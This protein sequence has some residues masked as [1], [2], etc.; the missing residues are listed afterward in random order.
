MRVAEQRISG[1]KITLSANRF[2]VYTSPEDKAIGFAR[3]LFQ[4]PRGRVG[5][6]SPD[7]VTEHLRAGMEFG[8]SNF[9]IIN[10]SGASGTP[11]DKYGHSYFRNAPTVSSDLVLMLRDDLDPGVP[12][13]P[14]QHVDLSFWSIPPGYPSISSNE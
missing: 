7:E 3:R 13:R 1:D 2:T 11:M 10:F 4:S 8:K 6:Y 9:S 12:E 5:T 14:L